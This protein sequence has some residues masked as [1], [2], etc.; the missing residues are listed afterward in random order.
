MIEAE[1][2]IDVMGYLP[3]QQFGHLLMQLSNGQAVGDP[4][5]VL[6]IWAVA[7]VLV[8]IYIFKKRRF[9]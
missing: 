5:L 2:L 8:T 3:D 1:R 7:S 9:D 6:S 4:F